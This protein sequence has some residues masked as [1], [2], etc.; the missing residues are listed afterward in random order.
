MT[1]EIVPFFV[2]SLDDY[3]GDMCVRFSAHQAALQAAREEGARMMWEEYAGSIDAAVFEWGERFDEMPE[4]FREIWNRRIA[5]T[6]ALS[7]PEVLKGK[8]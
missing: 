1:A 6:R 4:W 7:I 5:Y 8:T 2:P 3:A